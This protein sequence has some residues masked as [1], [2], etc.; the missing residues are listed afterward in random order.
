MWHR[1]HSLVVFLE[2]DVI[3]WM[4]GDPYHGVEKHL[5]TLLRLVT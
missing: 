2:T 4:A 5:A 1:L 3:G